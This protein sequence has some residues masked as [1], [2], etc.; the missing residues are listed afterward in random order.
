MCRVFCFY[1]CQ[2][3][4]QYFFKEYKPG[5]VQADYC[6]VPGREQDIFLNKQKD[7]ASTNIF[8]IKFN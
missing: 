2:C 6:R 3:Q 8:F 7:A 1:S 4:Q 5:V